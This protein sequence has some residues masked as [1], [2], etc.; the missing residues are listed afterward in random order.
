VTVAAGR[1]PFRVVD[2]IAMGE[3]LD[4]PRDRDDALAL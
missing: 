1:S 4:G 3:L 2:L